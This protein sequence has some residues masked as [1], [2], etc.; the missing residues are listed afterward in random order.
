M[1]FFTTFILLFLSFILPF[2]LCERANAEINSLSKALDNDDLLFET[3]GNANWF[4]QTTR[5]YY[6]KEAAQSGD[7]SDAQESWMK[8]TVTGPGTIDF[9]WKCSSEWGQ[10]FLEFFIDDNKKDYIS[11][12]VNWVQQTF[13]VP[14]G[15]HTL[16]WRYMKNN[17]VSSGLDCGFVDKVVWTPYTVVPSLPSKPT[18]LSASDGTYGSKI[19]VTWRSS[20][21][22]TSY[23]I[24]RS[25]SA[26]GPRLYVASRAGT[27]FDDFSPK[28][29]IKYYYWVRAVNPAGTS[30]YTNPDSG[31]IEFNTPYVTATDG[32][33]DDHIQVSWNSV[34]DATTYELYRSDSIDGEKTKIVTTG[35]TSF[36]DKNVTCCNEYFY[37]VKAKTSNC[38][39]GF[40]EPDSGYLKPPP[41][42]PPTDISASDGTF[43]DN[44]RVTW[45]P[46]SG[47]S[48]YEVYRAESSDGA[49]KM[50]ASTS[51]TSWNDTNIPCGIYYYWVKAKNNAGISEFSQYDSG[52]TI[53]C[54]P[55]PKPTGVSA[56]DGVYT[57]KI[58]ISWNPSEG[59]TSYEVYR[60]DRFG[61]VKIKVGSTSGTFFDDYNA[62][63][64]KTY[65][66]WVKALKSNSDSDFSINFDTGYRLCPL[67]PAYVNASD[68]AYVDKIVISWSASY[69][70]TS[71]E[72][73]RAIYPN[74]SEGSKALIA[75]TSGTS[76]ED[77]RPVCISNCAS[78]NVESMRYYYWVKAKSQYCTSDFSG[79]DSG[80]THCKPSAPTG[81]KASD[82]TRANT[83][84]V[85]WSVG[86]TNEYQFEVYRSDSPNGE[87]ILLSTT[88]SASYLDKSV[89]C[90]KIYY[91]WVKR[92]DVKGFTSDFSAFDS[93]YWVGK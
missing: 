56:S 49:K 47:A 72:V 5:H 68:D 23:K 50:V 53:Q 28:C 66:Y 3:G 24:Y 64:S 65:Y 88:A 60:A 33:F 79:Y 35:A 81:V 62:S 61:D 7:I 13:L 74:A 2:I 52:Y 58:R 25:T 37:W 26:T 93:G 34:S 20:S 67:A 29:G 22:A 9:Y 70:A 86:T 57:D 51:N 48:T 45:T 19:R 91:Y 8:T 69:G 90:S 18:G 73:Y 76:Y 36:E 16:T 30:A 32:T 43:E 46:S 17:S 41:P 80:F 85:T 78:C 87:K 83:I 42:A 63:I 21:G 1:R 84:W 40:S 12:S 77:H 92:K 31:Y 54:P 14:A 75:T 38:T 15:G 89:T 27:K 6:G 10:D 11:G 59:S 39:T 44:I 55:P 71:Y 4:L 82:G